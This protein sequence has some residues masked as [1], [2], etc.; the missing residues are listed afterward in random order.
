MK[1]GGKGARAAN[2]L[3]RLDFSVA[4]AGVNQVEKLGQRVPGARDM[5]LDGAVGPIADRTAQLESTGQLL[6]PPAKRDSLNAA[7]EDETN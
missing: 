6:D 5:H 3:Y 4:R 1:A 7:P 2:L